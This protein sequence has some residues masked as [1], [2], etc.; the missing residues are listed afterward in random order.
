MRCQ[1]GVS[2]RWCLAAALAALA[3]VAAA[4][5]F[6][7]KPVRVISPY[8]TGVAPDTVA[9]LLA[10]KL[11]RAWGQQVIVEPRPGASGFIALEAAKRAVPDGHE[12]VMADNGH[13]AINPS[14]F[15]NAPYDVER[16]FTAVA[17]IYRTDFFVA[18]STKGRYQKLT[19]LIAA[20]KDNPGRISYST[21]FIGSPHHLGGALLELLTGTKMLHVPFRGQWIDA[22][23]RGD[24]DWGF[25][26]ADGPFLRTGKVKL[27]AIAAKSRLPRH[28]DIPTVA[29]SGGPAGYEVSA[30]VGLLAP[31]ST[32]A[33]ALSAINR[34]VN[35]A[36]GEP[37]LRER[38]G[39]FGFAPLAA[40]AREFS[41]L[42]RADTAKYG[43]IVRQTGAT[44]D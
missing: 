40:S 14:L 27:I 9:R 17:S 7:T 26:P 42:I 18:V 37:E 1:T 12:L 30:W 3:G 31:K 5:S 15:K 4:Q 10:D 44:V 22:I 24:V 39:M 29:E 2:A 20:A 16:E 21:P 13:L 41:E 8:P 19:D 35:R 33:H 32:P 11:A 25:A 43:E 34:E 38:L 23:G 36:L 6:P 28:P